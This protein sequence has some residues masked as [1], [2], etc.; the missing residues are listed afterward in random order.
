M[1]RVKPLTTEQKRERKV[2]GLTEWIDG[3]MH[4][5]KLTQTAMAMALGIS[6]QAFSNRLN[7]EKYRTGE[8]KDPFSY[9]DLLVIFRL[10][11]A[12]PEEK[13]RLLTL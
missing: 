13:E 8:I 6:Q 3:R 1:P 9:G 10:L 7:P 12:T 2:L 4:S 11:E 5:R